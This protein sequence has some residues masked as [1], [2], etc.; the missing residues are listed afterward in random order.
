MARTPRGHHRVVFIG[1]STFT[2][3][4]TLDAD[5]GHIDAVNH[6][7]GGSQL[8]D[9]LHYADQLVFP[10]EPKMVVLYGGDNDMANGKS[11]ETVL[12]DYEEFAR[13]TFSRLPQC[14][15]LW[16]S[17]K[18]SIARWSLYPEQTRV[19]EAVVTAARLDP[20]RG[21]LDI[22]AE[23]LETDGHP[24]A[25]HFLGDGLHLSPAGY[26][27]WAR[28]LKPAVQRELERS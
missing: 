20:R 11:A 27:V 6:G 10:Y 5:L 21:F 14:R 23:M 25:V 4:T 13:R 2:L 22:R 18:P 26:A 9:C 24:Q 16:L 3:W 28:A 8:S 19:N 1:S 7:F 15:L 17:I 12:A